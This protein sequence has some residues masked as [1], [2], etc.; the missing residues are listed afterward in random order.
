MCEA[1]RELLAWSPR[2]TGMRATALTAFAVLVFAACSS[3]GGDS[4]TTST[5]P[6]DNSA[7]EA[8]LA[9]TSTTGEL[10]PPPLPTCPPSSNPLIV[11]ECGLQLR[12]VT[13]ELWS[14]DGGP[15]TGSEESTCQRSVL[16]EIGDSLDQI[17]YDPKPEPFFCAVQFHRVPDF[18]YLVRVSRR[19]ACGPSCDGLEVCEV[20]ASENH[21]AIVP[22]A[23]GEC[24]VHVIS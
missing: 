23:K 14:C 17:Y 7:A 18:T 13:I 4:T 2:L 11:V 20:L 15:C 8:T 6:T 22:V 19:V 21:I 12:T 16:L 9:P 24:P 3:G 10:Q 1:R 5:S